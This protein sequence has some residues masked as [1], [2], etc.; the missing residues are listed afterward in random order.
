MSIARSQTTPTLPMR[1]PPD[2]HSERSGP[3]LCFHHR[4]CDDVGPRSE[5]SLFLFRSFSGAAKNFQNFSCSPPHIRVT[6]ASAVQKGGPHLATLNVNIPRFYCLLRKEFLYDGLSHH[7][8][9]VNVCVFAVSSIQGR[10]L[11]FHVLTDSGAVIRRLPIH[12]LCH[13]ATRPMSRS[14]GSNS[15]IVSATKSLAPR[16]DHSA[17]LSRP[18]PI[19]GSFLGRRPIHVHHRLVR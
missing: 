3:T 19:E 14:T 8:E 15:G 6:L 7:N 10:A 1:T 16:L 9:F 12:A 17:R 13:R 11:G 5:E 2:G 4:S 18:R